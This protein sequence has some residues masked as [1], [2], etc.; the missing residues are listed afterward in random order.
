[1][2]GQKLCAGPSSGTFPRH[3]SAGRKALS[4]S[5][6]REGGCCWSPALALLLCRRPGAVMRGAPSLPDLL[7]LLFVNVWEAVRVRVGVPGAQIPEAV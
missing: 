3:W 6:T 5:E 1:M 7:K 4:L 2:H